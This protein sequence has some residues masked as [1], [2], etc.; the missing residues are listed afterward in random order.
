MQKTNLTQNHTSLESQD[1]NKQGCVMEAAEISTDS[2]GGHHFEN[3]T[4]AYHSIFSSL[5]TNLI[6]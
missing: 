2:V 4:I 5:P 6:F 1:I 3:K